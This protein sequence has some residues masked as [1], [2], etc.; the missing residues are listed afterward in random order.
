MA[1]FFN[2]SDTEKMRIKI[3][4]SMKI[5][6]FVNIVKKMDATSFGKEHPFFDD[7]NQEALLGSLGD[8]E[9]VSY[10]LSFKIK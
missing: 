6:K 8:L 7:S 2:G 1:S 9:I 4:G 10:S 5:D 3:Y